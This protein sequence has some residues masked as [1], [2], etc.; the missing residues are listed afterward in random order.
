MKQLLCRK[1]RKVFHVECFCMNKS[2]KGKNTEM[3]D[4]GIGILTASLKVRLSI[5][6][7]NP[8]KSIISLSP[9][10]YETLMAGL[11]TSLEQGRLP[12][13]CSGIM[14][15]PSF[16]ILG[17]VTAA[18]TVSDFHRIPFSCAWP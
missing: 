13:K 1:K 18:G 11:L 12:A 10:S 15:V 3:Q 16:P 2:G 7:G 4:R 14:A 8:P 9:E 5:E 6:I 17:R